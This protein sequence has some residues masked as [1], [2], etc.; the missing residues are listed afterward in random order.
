MNKPLK[1][2]NLPIIVQRDPRLGEALQKVETNA[3]QGVTG[4]K[5]QPPH[6]AGLP[7]VDPTRP[8]I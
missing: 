5:V 6:R 1:V 2:P 7:G 4:N 8:A 3:N